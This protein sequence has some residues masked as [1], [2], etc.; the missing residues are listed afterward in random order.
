MRE[1]WFTSQVLNT[2]EDKWKTVNFTILNCTKCPFG[3]EVIWI[4]S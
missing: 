1:S 2:E 3:I 4:Q